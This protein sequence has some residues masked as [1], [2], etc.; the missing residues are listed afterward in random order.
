MEPVEPSVVIPA[1]ARAFLEEDYASIDPRLE[2]WLA[3][4]TKVL[5]VFTKELPGLM[6][7]CTS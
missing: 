1:L 5:I 6:T 3:E 4:L 7:L 2:I